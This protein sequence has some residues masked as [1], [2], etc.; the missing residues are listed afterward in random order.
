MTRLQDG[1]VAPASETENQE[2][3]DP[4]SDLFVAQFARPPELGVLNL[5]VLTPFQRALLVID[6]TVTKFIEAFTMEPVE[7]V[8][9]AQ[10]ARTL[11]SEHRWLET[12]AGTEVVARQVVLEGKY[13]RTVHAYASSL[14]VIDR[15]PE[16]ARRALDDHEGGLG[17]IL[18]ASGLESRREVLW[19][20]REHTDDLPERVRRAAGFE[21]ISRTYR[22]ISEGR[23]LM[24]INEKFPLEVDPLPSHH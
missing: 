21:F 22:I 10:A 11:D 20:G 17:R 12:P 16:E 15:L 14:V 18:L 13:S 24:L 4:L 1:V 5:R 3:F 8:R 19:Y 2:P 9:V 23:P 6:G 7:V